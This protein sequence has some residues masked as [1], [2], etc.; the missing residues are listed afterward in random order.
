MRGAYIIEEATRRL[1]EV[2]THPVTAFEQGYACSLCRKVPVAA[3]IELHDIKLPEGGEAYG[4]CNRCVFSAW[5]RWR[6]YLDERFVNE[7]RPPDGGSRAPVG[8]VVRGHGPADAP[9]G[10]LRTPSPGGRVCLRPMPPRGAAP[11]P[12]RS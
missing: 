9:L 5:C 1:D 10:S 7:V 3:V 6:N 2:R 12:N 11:S 8:A 4:V